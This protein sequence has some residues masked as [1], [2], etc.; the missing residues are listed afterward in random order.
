MNIVYLQF[1][2]SKFLVCTE[3][4]LWEVELA[5]PCTY[6]AILIIKSN[7][8]INFIFDDELT[9]CNWSCDIRSCIDL[10]GL[11]EFVLYKHMVSFY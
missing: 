7:V 2:F 11:Y 8:P 4:G 5:M 10:I 6:I 9:F 1:F 3:Y